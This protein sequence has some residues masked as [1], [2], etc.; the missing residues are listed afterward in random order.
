[1][2]LGHLFSPAWRYQRSCNEAPIASALRTSAAWPG[3]LRERVRLASYTP[4]IH[5]TIV[6]AKFESLAE[7][8]RRATARLWP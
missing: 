7:G 6:W 5:P 4:E 3:R 2:A 8:A 1:M